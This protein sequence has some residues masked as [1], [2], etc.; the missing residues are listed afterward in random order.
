MPDSSGV[1]ITGSG[2]SDDEPDT[3]FTAPVM[4]LAA[5]PSDAV[6]RLSRSG[7]AVVELRFGVGSEAFGI[8]PDGRILYA[9]RGGRL[10]IADSPNEAPVAPR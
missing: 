8:A 7:T 3:T 1:L 4:P 9:D 6:H 5:G 10:R 2:V